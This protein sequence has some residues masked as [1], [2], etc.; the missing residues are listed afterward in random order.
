MDS[1]FLTS[2]QLETGRPFHFLY[3][4]VILRYR[5]FLTASPLGKEPFFVTLRKLGLTA[6][7]L[8][9]VY[10]TLRTALP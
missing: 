9:A 4:S 3:S 5:A 1:W 2:A 7:I 10:M 8:L 6:S